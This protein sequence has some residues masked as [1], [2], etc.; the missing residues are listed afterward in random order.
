MDQEQ[1]M[2]EENPTGESIENENISGEAIAA[3]FENLSFGDEEEDDSDTSSD[4]V[5]SE[6]SVSTVDIDEN[7]N[8]NYDDIFSDF[9]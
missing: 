1:L 5:T 3:L 4:D 8:Q 2:P 6:T 9:N 7:V